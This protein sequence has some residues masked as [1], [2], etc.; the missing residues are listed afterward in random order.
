MKVFWI[1]IVVLNIY[2][3]TIFFFPKLIIEGHSMSPTLIN[4]EEVFV[5]NHNLFKHKI[6]HGDIINFRVKG[7]DYSIIKRVVGLPND[8]IQIKNGNLIL[9]KK[10]VKKKISSEMNEYVELLQKDISYKIL[11][12]N[13]TDDFDNTEEYLVPEGHYFVLGDNR[14]ESRD[15]REFGFVPHSTIISSMIKKNNFLYKLNFIF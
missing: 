5:F 13:N 11:N 4:G 12:I 3:V 10:K 8:T 15:S 7:D 6:K 1:F 2:T 9:N 14:D